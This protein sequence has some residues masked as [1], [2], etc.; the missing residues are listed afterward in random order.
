MRVPIN[1]NPK[2]RASLNPAF[3]GRINPRINSRINPMF[4]SRINPRF[5]SA[6]NPAFNSR[7]TPRFNSIIDPRH[8]T[9]LN[10][11]L[12]DSINPKRNIHLNPNLNENIECPFLFNLNKDAIGFLVRLN[13]IEELAY[14]AFDDNLERTMYLF[15]N[16]QEGLNV[17]DIDNNWVGYCICT[18]AG[19]NFHNNDGE[20]L[21]FIIDP[22][23][24]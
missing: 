24:R 5:C 16:N 13:S 9:H 4:N 22:A 14:V 1:L 21:A 6:I 3:N 18:E 17:F 19:Y 12:N 8:N 7:I 15:S 11:N 23:K 20:W 10:P 2:F